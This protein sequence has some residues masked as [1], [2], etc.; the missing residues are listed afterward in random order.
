[1]FSYFNYV[2]PSSEIT[3]SSLCYYTLIFCPVLKWCTAPRA[4]LVKNPEEWEW[5]SCWR[6]KYGTNNQKALLGAWPMDMPD[7]YSDFLKVRR[8]E[9]IEIIRKS[10]TKGRPYGESDWMKTIVAKFGLEQTLR[11]VGRP[12]VKLGNGG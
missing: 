12:C 4:G 7:N 6:R 10:V 3:H 9:E 5:S 1:M 11:E 2:I 8:E